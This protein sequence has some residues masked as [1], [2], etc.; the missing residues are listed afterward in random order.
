MEEL[1]ALPGLLAKIRPPVEDLYLWRHLQVEF[2]CQQG[3]VTKQVARLREACA[4][5][6]SG[7][8]R[9]LDGCG[10][11]QVAQLLGLAPR[12]LPAF[13]WEP[14]LSLP[15]A[16]SLAAQLPSMAQR[17]ALS[18]SQ[19]AVIRPDGVFTSQRPPVVEVQNP[20]GE[21]FTWLLG[22]P[23]PSLIP[24]Q[25]GRKAP[26]SGPLTVLLHPQAAAVLL[27]ELFGHPLEADSFF[28]GNSPWAGQLGRPVTHLPLQLVDDPTAPSPGSFLLDDEGE[29][30]QPKSLLQE[31]VLRGLLA[32]RSWSRHFPVAAGN[33]RRLCPH[34]PPLPRIA[35]LRAW[36]EGGPM[37]LPEGEAKVE[38]TRVRSGVWLPAQKALLLAVSESFQGRGRERGSRY[39]PFYLKLP[40]G[41]GQPQLVAG[42][43]RPIPVA[44]PGWC[45]KNGQTLAVGAAASWL[46]LAGVEV[47]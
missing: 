16:Q 5:R 47:A 19:V 25:G 32:D 4:L 14:S 2:L 1:A 34:F 39:V 13:A 38:I 42:G 41:P 35:H 22:E 29:P 45:S 46:F 15:D 40:V 28:T 24:A 36:V 30:A 31:G 18:A 43:G 21:T 20:A 3:Q 44:E 6:S 9:S 33:A 12:K 27:H 26:P 23:V 37:S 7:L 10:R 17:V 8:L 11:Q